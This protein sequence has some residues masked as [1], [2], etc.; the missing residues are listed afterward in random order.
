[1]RQSSYFKNI[2]VQLEYSLILTPLV[3]EA[4]TY[5]V[6]ARFNPTEELF[7]KVAKG[8]RVHA[9]LTAA[10]LVLSHRCDLRDFPF[11][12]FVNRARSL[13]NYMTEIIV[14]LIACGLSMDNVNPLYWTSVECSRRLD[15]IVFLYIPTPPMSYGTS[16]F[17]SPRPLPILEDTDKDSLLNLYSKCYVLS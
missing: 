17:N 13:I 7:D 5:G 2:L 11:I 6:C 8:S 15:N 12:H 10:F 16:V 3:D 1:M 4:I 9:E 14:N